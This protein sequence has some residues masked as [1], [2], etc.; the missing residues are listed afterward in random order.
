MTTPR[1]APAH[2]FT[3]LEVNGLDCGF[4]PE[5]IDGWAINLNFPSGK[6]SFFAHVSCYEQLS[7]S[8][9]RFVMDNSSKFGT[10]G[11]WYGRS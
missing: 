4:C 9:S 10:G 5:T 6:L 2:I 11:I 3:P 1:P 7:W 8:M